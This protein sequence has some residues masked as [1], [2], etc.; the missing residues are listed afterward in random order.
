MIDAETHPHLQRFNRRSLERASKEQEM[1]PSAHLFPVFV[2]IANPT[3][4]TA[5]LNI[6]PVN[7]HKG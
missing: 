5:Q 4:A 2:R 1:E 6:T 7:L 3:G